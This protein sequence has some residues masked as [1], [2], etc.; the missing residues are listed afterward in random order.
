MPKEKDNNSTKDREL[1]FTRLL[2][3]P[4]KLVWDVWT[5]PEH[6]NKWWGPFD[7]VSTMAKI[8]LRVG[9]EWDLTMIGKDGVAN[10][11]QCRYIEIV[12]YKKIVYEQ[13]T[14]FKYVATITFE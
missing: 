6:L 1:R 11:H 2:D 13:L 10:R 12:K 14:H 7:C 3:A 5:N 4:I 9:G 8:D